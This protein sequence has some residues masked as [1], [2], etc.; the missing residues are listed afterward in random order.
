M[1][2]VRIS[3]VPAAA[4]AAASNPA[5]RRR[6][7]MIRSVWRSEAAGIDGDDV[8]VDDIG[9][10]PSHYWLA[11]FFDKKESSPRSPAG[12]VILHL[13]EQTTKQDPLLHGQAGHCMPLDLIP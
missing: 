7:S 1:A 13:Q 4:K 11:K 10:L 3:M 2:R 12:Q 5:R 6:L 8:D 9:M